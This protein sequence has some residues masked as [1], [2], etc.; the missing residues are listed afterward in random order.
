MERKPSSFLK[1][2]WDSVLKN[3]IYENIASCIMELLSETGDT[4]RDISFKEYKSFVEK[5]GIEA[6]ELLFNIVKPYCM[7]EETAITFS[8]EWK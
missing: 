8:P 6:S 4:F 7:S 1:S 5:K 3:K 2:P